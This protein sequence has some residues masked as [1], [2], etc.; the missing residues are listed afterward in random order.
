MKNLDNLIFTTIVVFCFITFFISTF[1]IFE[2]ISKKN[3]KTSN[4][5][6]IITHFLAYLESLVS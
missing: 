5:K 4:K 1:R 3:E 6:R 2:E